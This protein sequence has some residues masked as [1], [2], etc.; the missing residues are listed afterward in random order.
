MNLMDETLPDKKLN[1]E[2]AEFCTDEH[3][4]S[5]LCLI[6]CQQCL[7]GLPSPK[8]AWKISNFQLVVL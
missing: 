1:C 8:S 4:S 7:A 2:F 3:C 5:L 6:V